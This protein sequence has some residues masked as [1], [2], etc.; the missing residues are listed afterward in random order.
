MY[1]LSFLASTGFKA[2]LNNIESRILFILS[3]V[4]L[5]V[6]SSHAQQWETNSGNLYF[7]TGNV[8]IGTNNPES[9]LHL[10]GDGLSF[11][12]S[13]STYLSQGSDIGID[14][15]QL[16]HNGAFRTGGA[17][18]SISTDT[19][20][21]GVG[22]TY[23]SDLVLYSAGDGQLVE[24]IRLTAIGNIGVGTSNPEAKLHIKGDG[25]SLRLTPNT[26]NSTGSEIGV[27]FRQLTH[28]GAFRAGGAIKSIST[29]TYTGGVG[30]TY[31]SDIVLYSAEAGLLVEG[32]RV[33][34]AGNIG[35]GTI[36]PTQK[37][38]VNGK[39][40]AEEII[41]EDVAGA[42]FVFEEDYDLRTL[43]ETEQF[44]KANKHLPEIPSA[45]EMAEEG[46]AIKEMNILL[47]QKVEELTLHLIRMEKEAEVIRQRLQVL[48][49]KQ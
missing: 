16:T 4:L 30:S 8:G 7:N 36:S 13:R 26:Y 15:R 47:L 38:T 14:F 19:Y 45:A 9:N 40:N 18:K 3:F 2:S 12:V 32:L 21:G 31:K 41:L 5:I 24:G 29:G 33:N 46:L 17:I 11:W 37:L 34:S 35:I 25:L 42:D 23:D 10:K 49:E 22:S 44:I 6:F 39:I 20:T 28:N 1:F 48:E 27:D 43:E